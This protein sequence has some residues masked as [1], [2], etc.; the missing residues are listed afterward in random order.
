MY[1]LIRHAGT[2]PAALVSLAMLIAMPVHGAQPD[3]HAHG[4]EA[5]PAEEHAHGHEGAPRELQ[6]DHG[7]KWTTDAPLRQAMTTI[8]DAMQAAHPAIHA[9]KQDGPGYV[10]LA[11]KIDAQIAYMVEN[12]KL[13]PAADANLHVLLVEIIGGAEQMKQADLADARKGAVRVIQAL[14]QYPRYFEHPGWHA[15]Q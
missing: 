6:L 2:V 9:R 13:S 4:H 10:A 5:A 7:K 15:V 1:R 14:N 11:G 12:C 3:E 8:R